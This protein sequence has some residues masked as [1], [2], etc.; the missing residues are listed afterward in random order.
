MPFHDLTKPG[1]PFGKNERRRT[2]R[3]ANQSLTPL[4]TDNTDASPSLQEVKLK[5]LRQLFEFTDLHA[6]GTDHNALYIRKI[7]FYHVV[8]PSIN[9]QMTT[10]LAHGTLAKLPKEIRLDIF[11]HLV[12]ADYVQVFDFDEAHN[13]VERQS[14]SSGHQ[15]ILYASQVFRQ[16]AIPSLMTNRVCTITIG[17]SLCTANFPLHERVLESAQQGLSVNFTTSEM[18]EIIVDIPYRRSAT[19]MAAVR[20]NVR[21][22]VALLN[23]CTFA[24]PLVSASLRSTHPDSDSYTY[25]DYSMLLGPLR[26]LT[27]AGRGCIA[28]CSSPLTPGLMDPEC[29]LQCVLIKGAVKGIVKHQDELLQQQCLFDIKYGLA[30]Y[31]DEGDFNTRYGLGSARRMIGDD[32]AAIIL[33]ALRELRT[34][35][36]RSAVIPWARDMENVFTKKG[37]STKLERST[38]ERILGRFAV[39]EFMRWASGHQTAKNPYW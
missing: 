36:F 9:T 16:E 32:R 39:H 38:V 11:N 20:S 14:A 21:D 31:Q 23:G 15:A 12:T 26:R 2:W 33:N 4:G 6:S 1:Y 19:A 34:M 5:G 28:S 18:L 25:N 22:V 27:S 17:H 35:T 10:S 7:L 29:L 30:C 3:S 24:L 13:V 8:R 37:G